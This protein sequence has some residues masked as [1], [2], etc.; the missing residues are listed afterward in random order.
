MNLRNPPIYRWEDVNNYKGGV[1]KTTLAVE[2]S[3]SLA[4]H[5]KKRVL[6][7]D[8]DP[9]TNATFYLVDFSTWEDWAKS[10]E[11]LKSIFTAAMAE[12]QKELDIHKV[13]HQA[14]PIQR[15]KN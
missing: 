8:L 7:V 3:A 10:D 13:I 1:G 15:E 4:Y 6:L 5:Q 2:I 9:Q 12:P 11:T 14:F